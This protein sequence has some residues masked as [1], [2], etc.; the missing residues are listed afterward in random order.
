MSETSTGLNSKQADEATMT[1][2]TTTSARRGLAA[3]LARKQEA[4]STRAHAAGDARMARE[5]LTVTSSTG[6]F[7]FG[8]R[9]YHHPWFD[10]AALAL[11]RPPRPA[12]IRGLRLSAYVSNVKG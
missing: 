10:R 1:A 7:G 8:A 11:T 4:L 12:D 5:G 3:W 6:R 2:I 9:T